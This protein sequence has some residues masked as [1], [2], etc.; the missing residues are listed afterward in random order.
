MTSDR[1]K[2]IQ[3]TSAY[4]DSRSVNQALLQVWN[5]C[6]QEANLRLS[7]QKEKHDKEME[8]A[9]TWIDRHVEKPYLFTNQWRLHGSEEIIN[10]TELLTNFKNR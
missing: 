8:E 9:L 6:D 5:E 4:P 1:I 10:T 7:E 2:E 3:Q